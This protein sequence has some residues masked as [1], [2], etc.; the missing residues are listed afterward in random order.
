L[1]DNMSMSLAKLCE[2]AAQSG[3]GDGAVLQQVRQ[4]EEERH[5]LDQ[6][7]RFYDQHAQRGVAAGGGGVARWVE[8][9]ADQTSPWTVRSGLGGGLLGAPLGSLGAAGLGDETS[10][11]YLGADQRM[12][13]ESPSLHD[14][15]AFLSDAAQSDTLQG[16]PRH[17]ANN[18]GNGARGWGRPSTQLSSSWDSAGQRVTDDDTHSSFG[19]SAMNDSAASPYL[20]PGAPLR[21]E[22][23][24]SSSFLGQDLKEEDE[25]GPF[26]GVRVAGRRERERV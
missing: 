22:D 10:R 24:P 23:W 11:P 19:G 25:E 1:I 20:A 7:L 26:G 13:P 14:L 4:L 17:Q 21:P 18:N 5:T 8:T 15:P 3:Q 2:Q 9:A 12:I 6:Q 16:F